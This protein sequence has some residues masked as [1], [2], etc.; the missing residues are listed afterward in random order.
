MKKIQVHDKVFV[1]YLTAAQ[2]QERVLEMADTIS[3][4]FA[5]KRPLFLAILNGSFMFAA[6]VFR[7][8][9]IEAEISFIKLASYKG[10][11]STGNV[12]TAIGLEERINDRHIILVEDI[13]DTGKTLSAFMPQLEQ[14]SPASIHVAALLAKPEAL[15]YPLRIDYKGFEIPNKFVVGYGLDYDGLGRN[16]AE[17][18]QLEE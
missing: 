9:S 17:I 1:P 7:H 5:G 15:Q 14:Q 18:Y 10:T 16:I 6:D 8:L 13:I 3:N 4:D 11:T 2:I 12:I